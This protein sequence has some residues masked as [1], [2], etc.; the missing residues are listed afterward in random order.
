LAFPPPAG[1][2][3][4]G[5]R[6]HRVA[7]LQREANTH[8]S[9]ARI[10]ELVGVPKVELP[11]VKAFHRAGIPITKKVVKHTYDRHAGNPLIPVVMLKSDAKLAKAI[12]ALFPVF[13]LAAVAA[14][15]PNILGGPARTPGGVK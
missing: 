14:N 8:Q 15:A 7:D 12:T 4:E 10:G 2:E 3:I 11:T 9:L 1:A 5:A 6:H 13:D